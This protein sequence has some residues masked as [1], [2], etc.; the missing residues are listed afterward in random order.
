MTTKWLP[1]IWTGGKY[2]KTH[3]SLSGLKQDSYS[4]WAV[5]FN[6]EEIRQLNAVVRNRPKNIN[7]QVDVFFFWS[8][9]KLNWSNVASK[10]RFFSN[11]F[12]CCFESQQKNLFWSWA[13]FFD[14]KETNRSSKMSKRK[15]SQRFRLFE[16]RQ[17]NVENQPKNFLF[18]S[19]RLKLRFK[20]K[21]R[22]GG[23]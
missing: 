6:Q 17:Q 10:R 5:F 2:V 22:I 23:N 7:F 18:G 9:E 16:N 1:P 11:H 12:Y 21:F 15:I 19:W 13:N 20:Q 8:L 4:S 14:R 3:S